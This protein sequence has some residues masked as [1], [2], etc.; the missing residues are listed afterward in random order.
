[1]DKL[2]CVFLLTSFSAYLFKH[3][4]MDCGLE[5]EAHPGPDPEDFPGDPCAGACVP[6]GQFV[7]LGQLAV[8]QVGLQSIIGAS[9]LAGPGEGSRDNVWRWGDASASCAENL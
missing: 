8:P 3:I 4:V 6:Y 2:S 9:E 1:M 5:R 7:A